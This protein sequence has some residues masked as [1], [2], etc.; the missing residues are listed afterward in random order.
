LTTLSVPPTG[1]RIPLTYGN[2]TESSIGNSR[3]SFSLADQY[4]PPLVREVE[5]S[6]KALETAAEVVSLETAYYI[7]LRDSNVNQKC[8]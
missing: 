8:Y 4:H 6:S 3:G 1:F 2:R 5:L 7:Q